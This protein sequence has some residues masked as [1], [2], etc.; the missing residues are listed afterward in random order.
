MN[1][2]IGI[3]ANILNER[4]IGGSWNVRI[5]IA[6]EIFDALYGKK[7]LLEQEAKP[8]P[9]SECCR[10]G[11]EK[12]ADG[13]GYYYRCTNCGRVCNLTEWSKPKQLPGVLDFKNE[14]CEG[15][16][17]RV[18]EFCRRL[19]PTHTMSVYLRVRYEKWCGMPRPNEEPP[20][21]YEKACGEFKKAR[22]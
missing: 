2:R 4:G 8:F 12:I 16:Q 14:T 20:I 15:C 10:A 21:V 19:P 18:D 9:V 17:Y 3:I 22:E 6:E 11:A 13:I 1:A 5:D 7:A